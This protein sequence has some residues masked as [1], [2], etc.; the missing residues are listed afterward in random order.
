MGKKSA[1]KRQGKVSAS[2]RSALPRVG[3]AKRMPTSVDAFAL[4]PRAVGFTVLA[5]VLVALGTLP[6]YA[7]FG[8]AEPYAMFVIAGAILGVMCAGVAHAVLASVA[9]AVTAAVAYPAVFTYQAYAMAIQSSDPKVFFGDIIQGFLYQKTLLPLIQ[10]SSVERLGAGGV[11]VMAIVVCGGTAA[12]VAILVGS[13]WASDTTAKLFGAWEKAPTAR[14]ALSATLLVLVAVASCVA[15][16]RAS[17][18]FAEY[19]KG[20]LEAGQYATDYGIYQ[21]TVQLTSQGAGHY[22]ALRESI[23][24]DSRRLKDGTASYPVIAPSWVRNP[25]IFTVW[26]MLGGGSGAGLMLAAAFALAA[27]GLA[28]AGRGMDRSF[29]SGTGTLGLLFAF[30]YFVATGGWQFVYTPELWGALF[31]VLS[32][33]LL[34][35][36]RRYEG[37][38]AAL[39]AALCREQYWLWV[40]GVGAAFLIPMLV[41]RSWKDWRPVAA[42]TA[43]FAAVVAWF[44]WHWHTVVT[45]YADIV[46]SKGVSGFGIGF[47]PAGVSKAL[48]RITWMSNFVTTMQTWQRFSGIVFLA[49]A[50]CYFVARAVRDLRAGESGSPAVACAVYVLGWLAILV[51]TS[52]VNQMWGAML[53]PVAMVGTAGLGAWALALVRGDAG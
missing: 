39:L 16:A 11:L 48:V 14:G 8:S 40:A 36:G 7:L 23:A 12:G 15:G 45:S 34:W 19:S 29:G 46:T 53:M 24:N 1:K 33:G 20:A 42:V 41:R 32:A 51:F 18:P 2:A 13:R 5:G 30:P 25:F 44:V 26:R 10:A 21:R 4:T 31:L 47:D 27:T 28:F 6:S 9:F 52:H 3:T 49:V 17:A 35:S 38:A 43:G 22:E 37:I 50:T